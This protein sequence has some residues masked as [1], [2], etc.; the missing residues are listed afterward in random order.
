MDTGL[1]RLTLFYS[2]IEMVSSLSQIWNTFFDNLLDVYDRLKAHGF[3]YID[4][5]VKVLE[6]QEVS[7]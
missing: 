2:I 5:E 7:K 1:G 4:G 3:L 6:E